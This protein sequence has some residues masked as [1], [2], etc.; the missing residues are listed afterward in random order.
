M[1]LIEFKE[2]ANIIAEQYGIKKENVTVMACVWGLCG[3]SR[4]EV[5]YTSQALLSMPRSKHIKNKVSGNPE[6]ALESFGDELRLEF[7]E[8]DKQ[9]KNIEI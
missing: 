3:Q 7:K 4:D 5:N 2:K 1:T 8:Y 6:S 9:R